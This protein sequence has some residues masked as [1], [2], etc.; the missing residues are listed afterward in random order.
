[1][2]ITIDEKE[3]HRILEEQI[4]IYLRTQLR[5]EISVTTN[6]LISNYAVPIIEEEFKTTPIGQQISSYIVDQFT[7][8]FSK[9][10]ELVKV[11]VNNSLLKNTT[12]L[13]RRVT[14]EIKNFI[15]TDSTVSNFIEP[16]ITKEIIQNNDFLTYVKD[17]VNNKVQQKIKN[18]GHI[19]SDIMTTTILKDLYKEYKTKQ[20]GVKANV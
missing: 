19:T 16:L 15:Y 3:F 1:M 6:R 8:E 10:N 4:Q 20:L 14:N 5:N 12:E 18:I 11:A 9:V 7:Y 13:S 2:N 17:M